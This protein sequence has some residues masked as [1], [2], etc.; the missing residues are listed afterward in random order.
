[1]KYLYTLFLLFITITTI[2]SSA[3]AQ[4]GSVAE[5]SSQSPSA[6]I[7]RYMGAVEWGFLYGKIENPWNNPPTYVAS[8]S[9][10]FFNGYR[11]HRLFVIGATLGFDFYDNILITP[12]ALGIR[13]E[14]LNTRV[15]PFY[16]IDAG[17]GTAFLS[18]KSHG[19]DLDG[20]WLF[21]PA[22]GLRVNTG[23]KTAYTIGIGYKTQRVDTETISGWWAS[24]ITQRITYNRLSL[25]MGFMF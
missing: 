15:S 1:M 11:A 12:I 7:S 18:S 14:V 5:V 2:T 13:G 20:G 21:N 9:V 4:T 3:Q 22:L 24:Q 8:P 6:T 19:R 10:L 16:S 23:N 25:R 17:Y